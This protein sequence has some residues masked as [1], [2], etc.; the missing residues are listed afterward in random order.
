MF[1]AF[2]RELR[3]LLGDPYRM[4]ITMIVPLFYMTFY[5]TVLY[6]PNV[7]HIPIGIINQDRGALSRKLIQMFSADPVLGVNSYSDFADMQ[8]NL[9]RRTINAGI[10]I[11]NN[12]ESTLKTKKQGRIQI[13]ITTSNFLVA[14]EAAKHLQTV[15]E[16]MNAGLVITS[17]KAAGVPKESALHRVQPIVTSLISAGNPSYG[18][19]QFVTFAIL[20]LILHQLL[21]IITAQSAAYEHESKRSKDIRAKGVLSFLAGKALLYV[22][23]FMIYGFFTLN[24]AF[25]VFHLE[26]N[27]GW[28]SALVYLFPFL[29]SI[30]AMGLLAGSYMNNR[31][32]ALQ[33]IGASSVPL[34]LISGL[35]W[36]YDQMILIYRLL[37]WILPTYPMMSGLQSMTQLGSTLSE[38]WVPLLTGCLQALF[39]WSLAI[40]RWKKISAHS[41]I[42]PSK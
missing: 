3:M 10:I 22:G 33:I 24:V 1:K 8:Q 39:W 20:I 12:W 40:Y 5:G 14:N 36:P 15:C 27:V 31:T 17:L 41:I 7:E 26:M 28:L 18:Y 16:T 42:V 2:R 37:A 25:R 32:Q 30:S 29:V 23:L 13:Y 35:L 34:M 21:F 9:E 4:L 11:P 38:Q 19:S 6:T